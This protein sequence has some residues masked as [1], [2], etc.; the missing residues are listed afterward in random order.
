MNPRKPKAQKA[1]GAGIS[2]PGWLLDLV[3]EEAK[4]RRVSKS[5]V[6][7][8]ILRVEFASKEKKSKLRKTEKHRNLLVLPEP[9]PK[10]AR[11]AA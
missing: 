1:R 2:L 4:S 6:V 11:R 8:D 10:K 7:E 3:E 9:V 5:R